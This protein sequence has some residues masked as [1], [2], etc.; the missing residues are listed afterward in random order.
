MFGALNRVDR[1][2]MIRV[3][4]IAKPAMVGLARGTPH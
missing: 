1:P 3:V 4:Q 2:L